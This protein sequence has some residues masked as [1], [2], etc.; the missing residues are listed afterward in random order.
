MVDVSALR[1]RVSA[2]AI[3]EHAR[4]TVGTEIVVSFVPAMVT[5]VAGLGLGVLFGLLSWSWFN[6]AATVVLFT[7]L[8]LVYSP[9]LLVAGLR[10]ARR[11]VRLARFAAANGFA[12]D[13]GA[14]ASAS[15]DPLAEPN[16]RRTWVD[17]LRLDDSPVYVANVEH[18]VDKRSYRTGRLVIPLA[19]TV[20]HLTLVPATA[21]P[22]WVNSHLSPE[23]RAQVLSLEGDFDRH[24]TL[25]APRAYETDAL[26]VFTPDVM[27]ALIDHGSGFAVTLI[28]DLLIVSPVTGPFTLTDAALWPRL[29]AVVDSVAP[30]VAQQTERYRDE[31]SATPNDIAAPGRRLR[32]GLTVRRLLIGLATLVIVAAAVI[33]PIVFAR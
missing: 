18:Q 11:R 32:G 22:D 16:A 9:F 17:R 4:T 6:F 29:L 8:G 21:G 30:Q 7:A 33:L 15:P 1:S 26:Y 3:A 19:R 25:Y 2:A 12:Y 20:P 13:F 24:F 14:N 31:R 5:G 23:A 27:A 28:D 10:E